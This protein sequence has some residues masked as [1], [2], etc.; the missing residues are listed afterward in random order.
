MRRWIAAVG[1]VT[2]LALAFTLQNLL[3]EASGLYV[4]EDEMKRHPVASF[5]ALAVLTVLVT[6]LA[7]L[8]LGRLSRGRGRRDGAQRRD[9]LDRAAWD[10]ADA[11]AD[12]WAREAGARGL[13]EED[14]LLTTTLVPYGDGGRSGGAGGAGGAGGEARTEYVGSGD[15]LLAAFDRCPSGALVLSG[16]AGSGKTSMA[17][18]L[19]L[20][21]VRRWLAEAARERRAPAAPVPV[22]VSLA[23]WRPAG[24][25]GAWIQERL[26]QAHPFLKD[27]EAPED[28]TACLLLARGRILPVLDGL[29]EIGEPGGTGAAGAAGGLRAAAVREIAGLAR[30]LSRRVGY[31]RPVLV[32]TCRTEELREA[33]ALL[34]RDERLGGAREYELRPVRKAEILRFVDA[35]ND[36]PQRRAWHAALAGLDD[37]APLLR[38]LSTPLMLTLACE[39]YAPGGDPAELRGLGDAGGVPAIERHLLRG[40]VPHAFPPDGR[41]GG[42]DA[43]PEHRWLRFLAQGMR[44]NGDLHD[45]RWWELARLVGRRERVLAAVCALL[46][47]SP[48]TGLGFGLLTYAYWGASVAVPVGLAAGLGAG[49]GLAVLST[50]SLPPPSQFYFGERGRLGRVLVSGALVAAVGVPGGW[51]LFGDPLGA[52]WGLLIAT[53]IPAAFVGA[54]PNADA[55]VSS[56]GRLMRNEC[57]VALVFGLAYGVSIGLLAGLATS[58]AMGALLGVWSALAGGL[59]Y[60]LPWMLTLRTRNAGV[61]ALVHLTLAQALSRG[62]LPLRLL[63]FLDEAHRKNVLR[64]VGPTYQ[65]RHVWLRDVLAEPP[66]A[67]DRP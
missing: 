47:A 54:F 36:A 67:P 21:L 45:I 39:I 63:A 59:T 18:L 58:A 34:R 19:T 55:R 17:V 38:A 57:E 3:S 51:A 49:A 24:D 60:G 41:T 12:D 48:A 46:L 22:Y 37:G 30:G 64:R 35:V 10:L 5:A 13:A 2:A 14:R 9:R 50:L 53:P 56:P 40:L 52:L 32:L 43:V 26:E 66:P 4:P 65:F 44:D 62:D 28:R 23:G 31:G 29:D 8:L 61:V 15:D 33:D 16:A 1:V 27:A 6:G 11:V 20:G 42:T 25:L 7:A